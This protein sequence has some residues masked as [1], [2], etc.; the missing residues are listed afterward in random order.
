M[1]V[2]LNMMD[3]AERRGMHVSPEALQR[4]LGVPVIPLV[5][6]KQKGI[7]ELRRAIAKAARRPACRTGRCPQAMKEELLL[8]GGGLAILDSEDVAESHAGRPAARPA[9]QPRR[10]RT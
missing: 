6:H 8:V 4:E 10:P 7:D 2:A 3:V 5:G 1:V 9:T